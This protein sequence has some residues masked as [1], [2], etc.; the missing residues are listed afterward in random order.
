MPGKSSRDRCC[1]LALICH[2]LSNHEDLNYIGVCLWTWPSLAIM[3]YPYWHLV[4]LLSS[5]YGR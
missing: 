3:P 2:K 5:A 1:S 4:S